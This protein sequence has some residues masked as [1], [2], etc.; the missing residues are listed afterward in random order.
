M[1]NAAATEPMRSDAAVGLRCASANV[2]FDRRAPRRH[3]PTMRATEVK[4]PSKAAGDA[5]EGHTPPA[6][7][8]KG[9]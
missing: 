4:R 8:E 9:K 3:R 2:T 6:H 1:K 5:M 7:G